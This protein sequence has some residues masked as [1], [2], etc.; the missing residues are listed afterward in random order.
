MDLLVEVKNN[1]SLFDFV[2]LK[3]EIDLRVL[4]R[5]LTKFMPL[6]PDFNVFINE[7]NLSY[8]MVL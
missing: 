7:L 2:G 1:M 4:K 8:I 6:K 5:A 3:Q